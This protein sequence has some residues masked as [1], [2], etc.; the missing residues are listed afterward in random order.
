MMEVTSHAATAQFSPAA[1]T[2]A[3]FSQEL[4]ANFLRKIGH[5]QARVLQDTEP[6]A[7]H[8]MRVAMRRLRTVLQVLEPLIVLPKAFSARSISK[9]AKKMGVVRDLDVMKESLQAAGQELPPS[10]Q[11][12]LNKIAKSLARRRRQAFAKM[13]KSLA[14]S[15]R[16]IMQ[17]GQQWLNQP[18]Y[19]HSSMA[20]QPVVEVVP[21]LL[22]PI[23]GGF[24]L[25]GGWGIMATELNENQAVVHDLRKCTKRIRYQT[26]CFSPCLSNEFTQFLSPLES[27]QECL[28]HMQDAAVLRDFIEQEVGGEISKKMPILI[29]QLELKTE[30][31]WQEWQAIRRQLCDPQWRQSLRR[32][33]L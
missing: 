4:I 12:I 2:V 13:K 21:D 17:A 32:A 31:T 7:L 14:T 11:K 26:E 15:Y 23:I 18:L 19:R 29:D 5:Y 9:L 24:F 20:T 1:P 22:L 3:D 8:K 27:S 16:S 10:E 33:I 6:E 30:Q 25:H 28:G